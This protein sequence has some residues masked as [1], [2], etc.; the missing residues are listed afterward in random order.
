[1]PQVLRRSKSFHGRLNVKIEDFLSEKAPLIFTPGSNPISGRKSETDWNGFQVSI[2]TPCIF[3]RVRDK[4]PISIVLLSLTGSWISAVQI[5]GPWRSPRH[6][7]CS[8]F[9]KAALRQ[10]KNTCACTIFTRNLYLEQV[11]YP[12]VLKYRRHRKHY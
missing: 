1:M 3:H 2:A 11:V 12:Y 6:K 4:C 8:V 9:N 5:H 10:D 7:K